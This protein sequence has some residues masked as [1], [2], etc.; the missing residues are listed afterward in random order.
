MGRILTFGVGLALGGGL[1]AIEYLIRM[2]EKS[3][4]PTYKTSHEPDE[5]PA[6]PTDQ[7]L[8]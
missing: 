1:I 4:K 3:Q 8:G 2:R 5:S 6:P 7:S